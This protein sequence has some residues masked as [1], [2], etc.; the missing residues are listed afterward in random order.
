[1]SCVFALR[2]LAHTFIVAS[3]SI[4]NRGSENLDICFIAPSRVHLK[5]TVPPPR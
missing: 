4:L 2:V 5:A 3:G 1:M